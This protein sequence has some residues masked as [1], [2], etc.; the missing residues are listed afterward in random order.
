[1]TEQIEV[2]ILLV[3][4]PMACS[5]RIDLFGAWNNLRHLSGLR[6][7]SE[8]GDCAGIVSSSGPPPVNMM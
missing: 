1:M 7:E 8:E 6:K 2:G 4:T 3:Q 5:H